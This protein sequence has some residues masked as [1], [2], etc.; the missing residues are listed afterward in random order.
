MTNITNIE[1]NGNTHTVD[2]E[3]GKSVMQGAVE[4]LIAGIVAECGGSCSCGTCHCY[5]EPSQMQLVGS[6]NEDEQGLLDFAANVQETSRLG[7]Q[8]K[9]T[10]ALEGLTAR[11]PESQY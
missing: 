1:F 7:C 10:E 6:P 3:N 9:V 4:N 2:V 5:G 8:I 11:L